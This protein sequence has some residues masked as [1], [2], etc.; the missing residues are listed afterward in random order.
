VGEVVDNW[1]SR[2]IDSFLAVDGRRLRL[3]PRLL[4]MGHQG[5]ADMPRPRANGGEESTPHESS[6]DY[7]TQRVASVA[8][9]P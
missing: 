8:I 3:T 7:C 9:P 2:L 5:G 6:P 1:W 4:K